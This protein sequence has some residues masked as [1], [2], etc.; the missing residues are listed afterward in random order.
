MHG[1]PD[2]VCE[3]IARYRGSTGVIGE[4]GFERRVR[5]LHHHQIDLR[6]VD[7]DF[8]ATFDHVGLERIVVGG[9]FGPDDKTLRRIL[10]RRSRCMRAG[11]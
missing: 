11:G 6:T 2:Q 1:W 4:V 9:I 8:A 7:E 5:G 3:V 10:R